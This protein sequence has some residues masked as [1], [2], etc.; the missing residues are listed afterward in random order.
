MINRNNYEEYILLYLDGELSPDEKQAVDIFLNAN[1]DLKSEFELLQQTILQPE[2]NI[3]FAHKNVLYKK[4]AGI[5]LGNYQE[6]FL[7][8]IDE[9]LSAAEK[10]F[11]ETF[12][13][14]NPALQNEFTLLKQTVLPKEW[15][16]F[17]NKELLY[18]KEQKR[19]PVVIG[20]RW[21]SLA[22]A[23]LTGIIALVLMFNTNKPA[24]NN[25]NTTATINGK[26]IKNNNVPANNT[27]QEDINTVKP[28][29]QIIAVSG[30]KSKTGSK[31]QYSGSTNEQKISNENIAVVPQQKIQ[32][33]IIETHDQKDNLNPIAGNSISLPVAYEGA[34]ENRNINKITGVSTPDDNGNFI[35]PA[36]YTEQLDPEEE[37]KNIYVGA[38]QINTDKV[39]GFFRRAGRILSKLKNKD[40]NGDKVQV[41]NLEVNKLK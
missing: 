3:E 11:V 27:G 18:K 2:S 33:V 19:R 30:D 32:Q 12:V 6:Y 28:T 34:S 5:N 24:V 35:K 39:R 10:E 41:A 25:K 8:Y 14:K 40:D 31:N 21:A 9:E 13:L 1:P 38:L 16:V 36:A 26:K 7:L 23:I 29:E 37:N 15:V 22:A 20:L 4:D 17:T